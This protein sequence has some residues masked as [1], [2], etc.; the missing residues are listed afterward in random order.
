MSEQ[1]LRQAKNEV[2][3]VGV[4]QESTL[5]Q[6]T[7]NKKDGSGTYEA[8]SGNITLKTGEDETQSIS[9]FIKQLTADG[10]ENRVFKALNTVMNDLV[11]LADIAQGLTEGEATRLECQGELSLNEYRAQ[12]GEVKSFPRINGRFS[13]RRFKDGKFEPKATFDIEGIVKS[14]KPEIYKGEETGRLK[15]NLYVPLYGGKIIPLQFVTDESIKDSDIDYLNDYFLPGTSV[16]LAGRLVNKSKEIT[17]TIEMGFGANKVETTYERTRE[18]VVTGGLIYEEG[19]EHEKKI[20]DVSL[21][22]EALAN[23]ERHLATLRERD[24]SKKE[25]KKLGFGLNSA[26]NTKKPEETIE[27][28]FDNLFG[29]D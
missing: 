17:R 21:L 8:I 3:L 2:T 27:D 4:V 26:P 22:K 25:E 13:P 11:T 29:E 19:G 12:D 24:T 1:I 15:I 9:Y 18:F 14:V 20:F 16:N 10:K 5:E 23:R 7:F 6:K 28:N